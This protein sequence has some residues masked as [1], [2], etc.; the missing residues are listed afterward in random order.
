M[1]ALAAVIAL[2]AWH[3]VVPSTEDGPLMV[4]AAQDT[5]PRI[6]L[7]FRLADCG[8]RISALRAWNGAKE[9]GLDVRGVV[10]EV[11]E[12]N[13]TLARLLDGAG[14]EFPVAADREHRVAQ[15]LSAAG[16]HKTPV[17]IVIDPHGR[18]RL[19]DYLSDTN[20]GWGNEGRK[21]LMDFAR[22]TAH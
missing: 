7:A 5:T 6:L 2:H 13:D 11:S 9:A 15:A 1:F 16:F 22:T 4:L 10:L 20:E 18:M 19:V 21:I 3:G 12:H 8:T 17:A 14:L